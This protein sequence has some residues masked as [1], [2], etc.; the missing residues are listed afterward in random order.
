ME[1]VENQITLLYPK[2]V[3]QMEKMD[4][5]NLNQLYGT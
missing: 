1:I 2:F 5:R 4:V 3:E